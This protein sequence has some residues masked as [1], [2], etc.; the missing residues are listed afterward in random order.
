MAARGDLPGAVAQLRRAL[1]LWR[2]TAF[3][4]VTERLIVSAG[5]QLDEQR[6]NLSMTVAR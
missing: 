2:G 6:R 3:T 1:A 4:G 5:I